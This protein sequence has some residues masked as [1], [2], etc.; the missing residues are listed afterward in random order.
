MR[1]YNIFF[2]L[3]LCETCMVFIWC[4][5]NDTTQRSQK[6]YLSYP[7]DFWAVRS[8]R[9]W[10]HLKSLKFQLICAYLCLCMCVL[11]GIYLKPGFA[12]WAEIVIYFYFIFI[13]M[14]C[15]VFIS[16]WGEALC[17]FVYPKLIL[18]ALKLLQN[19]I[20]LFFPDQSNSWMIGFVNWINRVSWQL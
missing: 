3:C 10:P 1:G 18:L 20:T 9:V 15:C 5:F 4:L 12:L 7:E 14:S 6:Q 13:L 2:P 19:H 17:V 11:S 8:V 16:V